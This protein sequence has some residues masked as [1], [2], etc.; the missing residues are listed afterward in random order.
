MEKRM[1]DMRWEGC[2]GR[3]ALHTGTGTRETM[4]KVVSNVQR[5]NWADSYTSDRGLVPRI[6]KELKNVDTTKNK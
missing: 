2:K 5:K 1:P 6:Y 4:A 3:T